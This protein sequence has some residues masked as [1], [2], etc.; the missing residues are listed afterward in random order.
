MR[1]TVHPTHHVRMSN[2]NESFKAPHG[3]TVSFST[4]HLLLFAHENLRNVCKFFFLPF[5][6]SSISSSFH[7]I[8]IFST[9]LKF[10]AIGR[11]EKKVKL[12]LLKG[13]KKEVALFC[14]SSCLLKEYF[15]GSEIF[16]SATTEIK[17][18]RLDLYI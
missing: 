10:D 11:K 2:E 13:R 17:F 12:K 7:P 14:Q 18:V 9:S 16:L 3:T 15:S 8:H 4:I 5:F 6:P 1:Y